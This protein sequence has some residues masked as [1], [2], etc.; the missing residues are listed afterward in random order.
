MRPVKEEVRR[1]LRADDLGYDDRR[2][3]W[4]RCR[5]LFLFFASDQPCQG[6]KQRRRNQGATQPGASTHHGSPSAHAYSSSAASPLTGRHARPP[7]LRE[8]SALRYLARGRRPRPAT[9][10]RFLWIE[11]DW[12]CRRPGSGPHILPIKRIDDA[13]TAAGPHN[14]R[15]GDEA[16]FFRQTL[17]RL[18]LRFDQRHQPVQIELAQSRI[19]RSRARPRSHS[20]AADSRCR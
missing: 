13:M 9:L 14:H 16:E 2:R 20:R 4:R 17:R 18:I 11:H 10:T 12:I 15:P 19:R 3:C 8:K 6:Q 7:A 5:C 1:D